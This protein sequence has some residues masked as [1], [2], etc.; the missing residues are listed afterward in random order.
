M[1]PDLE[2]IKTMLNGIRLRIERVE[3]S[4]S[5]ALASVKAQLTDI[6][7][8]IKNVRI[9]SAETIKSSTADWGQNDSNALDYVKNRTH[10]MLPTTPIGSLDFTATSSD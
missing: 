1:F 7:Q 6:I 3:K 2:F 5:Q 4:I 9:E 8:D 10:Y